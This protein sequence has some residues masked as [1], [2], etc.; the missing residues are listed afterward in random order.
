M[1]GDSRALSTH[2]ISDSANAS[3]YGINHLVPN[4]ALSD[5]RGWG[6]PNMRAR[7]VEDER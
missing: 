2:N 1:M 3:L 4:D 7:T 5:R 6:R